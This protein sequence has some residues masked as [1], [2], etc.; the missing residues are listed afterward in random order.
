MRIAVIS[1]THG[2]YPACLPERLRGADEIWHLG[3]VTDPA[4]LVEF[5]QLGV[6]LRV[7]RGNCDDW[8][9]WP[10][11]LN[12]ERGGVKFHLVHIPPKRA[13]AGTRVLLHGH[14][15][16]PRDEVDVRGVRWLSPG[17]ISQPRG[18]GCSFAWLTVEVGRFH[19]MLETL[20]K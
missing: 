12:L 6:P 15:H 1:D 18:H 19:W 14:L 13:P 17:C 5:E 2:Q 9:A 8:P 3:D 7:V 10:L 4:V 20:E 16:V 11:T